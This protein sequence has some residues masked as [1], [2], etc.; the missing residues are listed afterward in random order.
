MMVMETVKTSEIEGEYLSRE[1]VMSS[2][3]NQLDLN[4][5][6]ISVR[7]KRAQTIAELM[8]AVRKDFSKKLSQRMLF[9][10]HQMLMKGNCMIK[11]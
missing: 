4:P 11:A 3:R 2:I 7:D 6:I 10:W 9:S 8:V 5:K 1:D